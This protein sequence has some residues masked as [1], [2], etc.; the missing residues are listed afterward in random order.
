MLNKGHTYFVQQTEGGVADSIKYIVSICAMSVC[1]SVC[2]STQ[3]S[4]V[5]KASDTE[6]G[7][8]ISVSHKQTKFISTV[9][10]HAHRLCKPII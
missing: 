5:I 8:E 10:C 4:A 7:K 6:F 9:V 2:L 1:Q 3:I